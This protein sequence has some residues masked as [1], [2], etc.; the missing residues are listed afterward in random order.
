MDYKRMKEAFDDEIEKIAG[1][2]TKAMR[3][4]VRPYKMENFIKKHSSI[5][6]E[7]V[8]AKALKDAALLAG[9]ATGYHVLRTAND[10]RKLGRQIR[11]QQGQ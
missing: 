6:K 11:Q 9:G 10:D 5:I 1:A 3:K 4:G 2:M 8:S 7:A